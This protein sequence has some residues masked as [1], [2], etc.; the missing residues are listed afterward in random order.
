[1][2]AQLVQNLVHLE[3]GEDRF[4]EDGR[5]DRPSRDPDPVLREAED[6]VPEASLEM[7]LELGEV[8][9]RPRPALEQPLGVAMEVHPEVEEPGG[10]VLAV[11][12]DV[13]LLQMPTARPDEE[14]GDLVVQLVPLLA[15]LKRDR[16]LDRVREVLLTADDVLPRGRVRVLEVGHVDACAGIEG[17]DDHLAVPGRAG[18]LDPAILKIRRSGRHAPLA[19]AH[20][21]RGVEEVGKL[22]ALDA[23]LALGTST[24]ELLSAASELALERNDE[25]ERLRREDAGLV[26]RRDD[27]VCGGHGPIFG[28]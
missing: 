13:T 1:M 4:D 18:D 7:A 23:L 9:V 27:G 17:V 12:L 14:N 26:G 10:D 25:L 8:E 16:P 22:A 15:L 19:V 11:D 21:A 3:R 24:E 2:L 28:S 20:G 5:L 6:V